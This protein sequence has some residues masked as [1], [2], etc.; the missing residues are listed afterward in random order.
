MRQQRT[1]RYCREAAVIDGGPT[2]LGHLKGLLTATWLRL[3][4]PSPAA[5]LEPVSKPDREVRLEGVVLGVLGELS[6]I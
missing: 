4:G 2:H 5:A 3:R 1:L 6:G